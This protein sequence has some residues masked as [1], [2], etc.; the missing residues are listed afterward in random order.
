MGL[1]NHEALSLCRFVGEI[2]IRMARAAQMVVSILDRV[3]RFHV[4]DWLGQDMRPANRMT[5]MH[6][7]TAKR[8]GIDHAAGVRNCLLAMVCQAT[9]DMPR[10]IPFIPGYWASDI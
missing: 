4:S 10:N 9:K 3:R 6:A 5:R 2:W 7:D 1:R 8:L